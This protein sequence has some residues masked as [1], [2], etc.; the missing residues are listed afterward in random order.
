MEETNP[1]IFCEQKVANNKRRESN[2]LGEN[3]AWLGGK[4]LSIKSLKLMLT[5]M[6]VRAF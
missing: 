5:D 1:N 6:K 4:Q 2:L 3:G